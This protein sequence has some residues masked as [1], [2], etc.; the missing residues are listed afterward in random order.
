VARQLAADPDCIVVPD[1]SQVSDLYIT[2][3]GAS[4]AFDYPSG[5]G[6]PSA[7]SGNIDN[8]VTD[9][10]ATKWMVGKGGV[11]E[12][13]ETEY[14]AQ[15][16]TKVIT[17]RRYTLTFEV[18]VSDNSIRELLRQLQCNWKSF[19]FRYATRGGWVF[20]GEDGIAPAFVNAQLPLGDGDEDN[21]LGRIII[22]FETANGDPPRHVDPY[23]T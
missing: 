9:N 22:E 23:A 15:K 5:G 4:D 1:L 3:T 13:E 12:P 6:D 10:S 16:G 8:T 2:P 20:G 21:E 19:T 14:I 11:A 7:T 17:K 18:I